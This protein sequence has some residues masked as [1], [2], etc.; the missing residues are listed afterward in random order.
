MKGMCDCFLCLFDEFWK[1]RATTCLRCIYNACVRMRM[2]IYI[3]AICGTLVLQ[4]NVTKHQSSF[5]KFIL[6]P[7]E[8]LRSPIYSRMPS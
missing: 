6:S 7:S 5:H 1:A 4:I 3:Y 2:Y 8:T